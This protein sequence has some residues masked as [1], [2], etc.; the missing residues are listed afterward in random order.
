MDTSMTHWKKP[1][2]M[3]AIGQTISL[4]GSSAV[5]FALIWWLASG[6]GSPMIMALSSLLAFL[7]QLI[8]G[9]FAGVWVDRMNR[10]AIAMGA[11][12]FIGVVA[13]VFALTFIGG[14]PSF[15]WVCVV[16]G[17]RGIGGV[18]HTPAI[19][20][21]IP[22]LV[23]KEELVRAGGWSQFMMSG[24]FMLGPVLGAA[25]F[26]I[27]PMPVILLSD[28]LGALV[29]VGTMALV[30]IPQVVRANP[31]APHFFR[32]MK[33]GAQVLLRD[34]KLALVTLATV[35]TLIFYMPMASYYPLMSS[36]YFHVSAWHASLVE[37]AYALGMMGTALIISAFGRIKRKF[38]VIY[39]GLFSM[40]LASLI[41]GLLPSTA[42][43]FW[44]FA[45]ACALMGAGA[46]VYN[47]PYTAYIQE[48]VPPEAQGRVFSLTATLMSITMPLGLLISGPVA[49]KYGVAHWFLIAG[50]AVIVLC[51][52]FWVL[53]LR[54]TQK[55]KDVV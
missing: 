27:L 5:Q 44:V 50:I 36:S 6:S 13:L 21:I 42:W 22:M 23:P 47:I 25:M 35:A 1:F 18:F 16:L 33:A 34:K 11:D 51:A 15:M 31:E 37:L 43:A 48:S 20:S 49:E 17:V 32:E 28:T 19:Q 9:P 24:A 40:G 55:N 26:A 14:T 29:A 7:P 2:F 4:I 53:H 52:A 39:A 3:I 46:N 45:F 8:L 41:S 10:K 12:L 38:P 30:K 54:L